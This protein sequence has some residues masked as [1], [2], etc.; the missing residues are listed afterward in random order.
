MRITV[1]V[2]VTLLTLPELVAQTPSFVAEPATIGNVEAP[3]GNQAEKSATPTNVCAT[4]GLPLTFTRTLPRDVLDYLER[5]QVSPLVHAYLVDYVRIN[6]CSGHPIQARAD[7]FARAPL[8]DLDSLAG[9]RLRTRDILS[10]LRAAEESRESLAAFEGDGGVSIQAAA[11]GLA[12]ELDGRD[13]L[14]TRGADFAVRIQRYDEGVCARSKASTLC[15]QVADVVRRLSAVAQASSGAA[16]AER[17]QQSANRERR[18]LLAEADSLTR[19]A[20]SEIVPDTLSEALAAPIR[21]QIADWRQ[22]AEDLRASVTD[23]DTTRVALADTGAEEARNRERQAVLVLRQ[24]ALEL[25][26]VR[27][28]QQSAIPVPPAEDVRLASL[29][30]AESQDAPVAAS[31]SVASPDI[32]AGLADFIIRRAEQELIL[33][34]LGRIH[35]WMRLEDGVDCARLSV[36]ID[37]GVREKCLIRA[38]FQDTHQLMG[39]AIETQAGDL[40]IIDAG[41]LPLTVWRSA[42]AADFRRLPERLIEASDDILCG[43]PTGTDPLQSDCRIR[44]ARTQLAA[45][46]GFRLLDGEP[47]LDVLAGLRTEAISPDADPEWLHATIGLRMVGLF[48]QGYRAQGFVSGDGASLPFILS[49]ST[50]D[51]STQ[52]VRDVL[53][54]HL[55]LTAADT[56][57]TQ[58]SERIDIEEL[59]S[60]LSQG[61]RQLATLTTA[62]RSTEDDGRAM[63]AVRSAHGALRSALD[64]ASAFEGN[65]APLDTNLVKITKRWDALGRIL[66]SYASGEYALMLARSTALLTEIRGT[67]LP[68]RVMT[69]AGL[70][71]GL[72]E[73]RTDA[74]V[75][76]AFSAAASPVGGWQAKRYRTGARYSITA[77]PGIGGSFEDSGAPGD[78]G[79][80]AAGVSLPVGL[81]WQPWPRTPLG[82]RAGTPFSFG[83]FFPVLDLGTYLSYRF[84]GSEDAQLEESPNLSLRQ[85]FAPGVGIAIGP[86]DQAL[87]FVSSIQYVPEFRR[88]EGVQD[89][90]FDAWRWTFGLAVDVVLFY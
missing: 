14:T 61:L 1:L 45:D 68:G 69:I 8:T 41:R 6:G 50:F 75:Q 87:S 37:P 44:L 67:A 57:R 48:A 43:D 51:T 82:K 73:A 64:L 32:L 3:A 40:N 90:S 36:P 20:D 22:E 86:G 77:Y 72:A 38:V 56:L 4:P 47:A 39:S 12:A 10:A 60:A 24:E 31:A 35:G 42:L 83:F 46:A 5:I 19:L 55:L 27:Q 88:V 11:S 9:L 62:L 58:V 84:E 13:S 34:Y 59:E 85:A 30:P 16:E 70:G 81:E 65:G 2:L 79:G 52:G 15:K 21:A 49:A 54:R 17:T 66:E 80:L 33:S 89:Q 71:V 26:N 74:Q 53:L 63:L 23:L 25:A 28:A 76:A 18:R 29:G 78:E 7:L